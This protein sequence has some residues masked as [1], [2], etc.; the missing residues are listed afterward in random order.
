VLT[1]ASIHK[2]V[3]SWHTVE[4]G[5]DNGWLILATVLLDVIVMGLSL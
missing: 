1:V 2:K 3:S 4:I 5:S